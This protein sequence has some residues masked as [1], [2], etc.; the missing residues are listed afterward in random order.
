MDM[1]LGP[2]P[3]WAE[4]EQF[5]VQSYRIMAPKKRLKELDAAGTGG[6]ATIRPSRARASGVKRRR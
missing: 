6:A 3:D 4:V 5:V 1:K 2:R